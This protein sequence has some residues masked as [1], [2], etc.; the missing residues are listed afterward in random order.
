[1]EK[2]K[3]KIDVFYSII[4]IYVKY[5]ILFRKIFKDFDT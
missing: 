3:K 1:M 4:K 5:L 2:K